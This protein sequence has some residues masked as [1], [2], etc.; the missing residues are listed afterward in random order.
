MTARPLPS[1]TSTSTTRRVKPKSSAGCAGT[2]I[3]N[4]PN[5]L[6]LALVFGILICLLALDDPRL[7]VFRLFALVP[8]G[9]FL[10]ALRLTSSRGGL[11]G[12]L[13]GL[14]V[15]LVF[16]FGWRRALAAGA[17]ALPV[18][19]VLFG[20][21]MTNLSAMEDGTGQLRLQL[22]RDGMVLFKSE[23]L[24]GVGMN[25]YANYATQVAHNSFVHA[26]TELGIVGGTV[27]LGL[28]L[29]AFWA[30]YRVHRVYVIDAD[31]RQMLP[32]M[33]AIVAGYAA[34][35]FSLSRTYD[36][37]TY[38]ILGLATAYLRVVPVYPPLGEIHLNARMMARLAGI[39][40]L[41]LLCIDL[42]VRFLAA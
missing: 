26:Y 18:L 9:L 39:S 22:W 41:F 42:T 12:L 8:P 38:T 14:T 5:D 24:S 34:G 1:R 13:A 6:C 20:G 28:F 33:L 36:V 37:L 2:G 32:F 35:I 17:V 21:R 15:L 16:R 27:F 30:L 29:Y 10:F 11:L 7:G 4:D 40:L 3:F 31:M 19:L 25:V 23:P